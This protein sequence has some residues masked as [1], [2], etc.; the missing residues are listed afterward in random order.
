LT[1][2]TA[3]GITPE[4]VPR[5]RNRLA[6]PTSAAAPATATRATATT[7]PA[8]RPAAARA[9]LGLGPRLV[10]D[11]VAVAEEPAVEHLDGLGS[12]FLRRHLDKAEPTRPARELIG[13]DAHRF[14][15]A[16]LL[17]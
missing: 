2:K 7:T 16:G 3:P 12:L 9:A 4:A 17:E 13:D 5:S 6:P 1:C 14:H 8:A 15:D 10:D 11:K